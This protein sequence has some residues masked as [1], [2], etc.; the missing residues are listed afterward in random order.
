MVRIYRQ[1]PD[2]GVRVI[3][4]DHHALA[5]CSRLVHRSSASPILDYLNTV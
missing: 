4:Y 3:S 2:Q 5:G 1:Q